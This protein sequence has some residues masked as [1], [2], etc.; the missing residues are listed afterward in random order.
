MSNDLSK[1][2]HSLE[3][4]STGDAF[5]ELF[6]TISPH[7]TSPGNL[8]KTIWPWT[9]DTHMAL[10]IVEVLKTYGHIEQDALARAFARRYQ[11]E[12][13]RGYGGGAA[14]LLHQ[15]AAGSDWRTISP[16]LFGTGSYGNGAAMRVAP[17]G[18]FFYQDLRQVIKEAQLSAEIPHAHPE[19]QAGAIA[20]AV[21]AAIAAETPCP[22]GREFLQEV[23]QL[24]PESDTKKGIQTALTIPAN[25]FLQAVTVLGSGSKVSAQDTVP[26]CLWSAAYHLNNYEEALWQ[27]AKGLGDCDTTCAIVGGIVSLSAKEIPLAWLKH[28]EPLPEGVAP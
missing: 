11:E 17:L 4:L 5:G 19:G 22:S 21:A 2:L 28:R 23:V 8:P 9:D 15:V 20:V 10:S 26:F 27:T 24:V 3:G 1:A 13:Y 25:E 6:F 16:A 14:R 18:G 12:P 7:H